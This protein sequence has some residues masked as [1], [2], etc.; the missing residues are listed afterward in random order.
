MKKI[1]A[2]LLLL[3]LIL[4][5]GCIQQEPTN[6]N[7]DT[8]TNELNPNEGTNTNPTNPNE[9]QIENEIENETQLENE[10]PPQNM[11]IKEFA[12]G[13]DWN[14]IN[15]NY[16]I[17]FE[18]EEEGNFWFVNVPSGGTGRYKE[19][20]FKIYDGPTRNFSNFI[21]SLIITE[22][23]SEESAS[24]KLLD[25]R[26]LSKE[27]DYYIIQDGSFGDESNEEIYTSDQTIKSIS[28]KK[29]NYIITGKY[30]VKRLGNEHLREIMSFLENEFLK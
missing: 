30:G 4:T 25:E 3:L 27:S 17:S 15:P 11:L 12:L 29:G 26:N 19:Y 8:N 20:E 23:D 13:L 1:I 9:T 14:T 24:K 6:E 22:W 7:I 16:E 10:T 2:L 5:S 21:I 18:N 28:F